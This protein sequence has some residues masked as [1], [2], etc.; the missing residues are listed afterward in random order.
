M[1]AFA[2]GMVKQVVFLRVHSV[3]ARS[4]RCTC[5]GCRCR[6]R[7]LPSMYLLPTCQSEPAPK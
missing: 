5:R 6:A 2:E 4:E 1:R 3:L 7:S